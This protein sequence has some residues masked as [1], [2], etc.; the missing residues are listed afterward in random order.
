MERP[1]LDIGN[2]KGTLGNSEIEV[3]GSKVRSRHSI[4][5]SYS[6][7]VRLK[8]KNPLF[9]LISPFKGK[10]V[11]SLK[12]K[13]SQMTSKILIPCPLVRSFNCHQFSFLIWVNLRSEKP[14]SDW[15]KLQL[16]MGI[17]V[18]H[19]NPISSHLKESFPYNLLLEMTFPSTL[20]RSEYF[21][22]STIKPL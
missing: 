20:P 13:F 17:I 11:F 9:Y 22:V 4:R 14:P 2:F 10:H 7:G 6:A 3:R 15:S 1:N 18:F 12:F 19:L 21:P 8:S 16:K 5:L